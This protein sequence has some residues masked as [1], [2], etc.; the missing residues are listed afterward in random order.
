MIDEVKI[1]YTILRPS[2]FF[3][4]YTS[5]LPVG[6]GVIAGLLDPE[7]SLQSV[8]ILDIGMVAAVVFKNLDAHLNEIVELSGDSQN[9]I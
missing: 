3:E 8:S 6:K 4:N 9:G 7:I 5:I 2:S 1:P